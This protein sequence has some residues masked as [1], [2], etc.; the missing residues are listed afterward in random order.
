MRV[1][2]ATG[3]RAVLA[4]VVLGVVVLAGCTDG[5][6]G[7]RAGSDSGAAPR[8]MSAPRSAA[9][10]A[11][12]AADPLASSPGAEAASI[13]PAAA[14]R[15]IVLT[16]ELRLRVA[17]PDRAAQEA[18]AIARLRGGMVAD[19]RTDRALDPSQG[20]SSTLLTLKV[21]PA[22]FDRALDELSRIGAVL[23]RQR[24]AKD[25]TDEVV[26]VDS[27][28]ESQR[29]S[30]ERT[31]QLM[32]K[33]TSIT[34]IVALESEL[35]RREA[36]LESLLKRQQ[37]LVAQTDLSTI[38]VTIEVEPTTSVPPK[39]KKDDDEGFVE[40]V[41]DAWSS[42]WHGI[43]NAGRVVSVVAAAVFPFAVVLSVLWLIE[44]FSGRPVRRS[45]ARVRARR[46][47]RAPVDAGGW[48]AQTGP[49]GFPSAPPAPPPPHAPASG[50]RTEESR[51]ADDAG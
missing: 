31:R 40:A 6:S 14:Q 24:T 34:D 30:V 15:R 37:T 46:R 8:D 43:Y 45:V 35:S 27:R 5:G 7:T 23:S 11:G 33:A 13:D 41:G 47:D 22:E 2:E 3:R 38:T 44:R 49:N 17:D 9:P 39:K 50:G 18:Q 36:D 26:D 20:R 29:R 28:I 42:G 10:E 21:A 25:V 32:A 19:E 4:G 51:P 1:R 48:R 12:K 16:A